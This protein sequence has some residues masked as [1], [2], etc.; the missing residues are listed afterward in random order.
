MIYKLKIR[1]N[2]DSKISSSNLDYACIMKT[3]RNKMDSVF[4]LNKLFHV[5]STNIRA[6]VFA[7]II[8]FIKA[9]GLVAKIE[10]KSFMKKNEVSYLAIN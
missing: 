10:D 3:W 4:D 9:D 5:D 7:E 6:T 2:N 1:E 8:T